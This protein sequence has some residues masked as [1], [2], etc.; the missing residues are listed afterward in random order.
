M[1]DVG[2]SAH[3]GG[4]LANAILEDGNIYAMHRGQV[5]ELPDDDGLI[6]YL[7]QV[8]ALEPEGSR[9]IPYVK[10]LKAPPPEPAETPTETE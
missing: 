9:L 8:A 3:Y 10:R 7:D 5:F 1:T 6:D 2:I 4:N